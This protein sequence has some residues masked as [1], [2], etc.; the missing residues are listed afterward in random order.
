MNEIIEEEKEKRRGKK[1]RLC[2]RDGTIIGEYLTEE[3]AV[4]ECW[5][6]LGQKVIEIAT[7]NTIYP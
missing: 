6:S 1:Y 4:T 5:G 7:G 3:E 2:E